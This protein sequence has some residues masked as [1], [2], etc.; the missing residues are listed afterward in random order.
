MSETIRL[1][2]FDCDG[3]L[4]DSQHAILDAMGQA[5]RA[6][7]REAPD[8]HA[9][10]RIIGLELSHAMAQLLPEAEHQTHLDLAEAYRGV[11]YAQRQQGM[12]EEPLF[13]GAREVIETL[14]AAG[15]MLG[16]ATGKSSRGLAEVLTGHGVDKYFSTLQTV[17]TAS[18]KPAPGMLLQAMS[19]TGAE[20]A[21]TVMIGDTSYDMLMAGNAHASALGVSWGYHARD[22]LRDAG[23]QLIIDDFGQMQ[24]ALETLLAGAAP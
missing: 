1:A 21:R 10:R 9:V 20:P 13:E 5:F 18:G 11:A 3:T 17:D 15:W 24:K 19:E 4:V 2:V 12:H 7:G 14:A 23:A 6:E 16:V 8:P 22:E